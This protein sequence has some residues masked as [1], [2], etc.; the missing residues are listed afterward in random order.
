MKRSS[1]LATC[2]SILF[3]GAFLFLVA[4]VFWGFL[5]AILFSLLGMLLVGLALYRTRRHA[6]TC[7]DELRA[8]FPGE[9]LLYVASASYLTD[10]GTFPGT[11]AVTPARICFFGGRKTSITVM[12][13]V[14]LS[15]LQDCMFNMF[16]YAIETSGDVHQFRVKQHEKLMR[17]FQ[18]QGI[19]TQG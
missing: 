2:L 1:L 8:R 17:I 11:L 14:P 10:R 18:D 3:A 7:A 13:D 4:Y 9:A 12:M 6:E 15:D 19:S 5:A 16:F